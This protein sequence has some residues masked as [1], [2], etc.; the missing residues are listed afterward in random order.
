MG[1]QVGELLRCPQPRVP[2]PASGVV[3]GTGSL[4][5]AFGTVDWSQAKD[6]SGAA[7]FMGYLTPVTFRSDAP[8]GSAQSSVAPT[9]T[10]IF[11]PQL[12]YHPVSC[13]NSTAIAMALMWDSW[14]S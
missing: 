5:L 14:D 7:L 11:C 13:P 2:Y 10:A 12:T 3:D 1:F 4:S 6:I 9:T 8:G